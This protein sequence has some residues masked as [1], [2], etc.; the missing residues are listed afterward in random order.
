MDYQFVNEEHYYVEML[1]P[2][3]DPDYV[4]VEYNYNA[5]NHPQI[6]HCPND[7]PEPIMIVG[8]PVCAGFEFRYHGSS[9]QF[10]YQFGGRKLDH[11]L[12]CNC[13]DREVWQW[14][15]HIRGHQSLSL[16]PLYVDSFMAV[17]PYH[18][19]NKNWLFADFHAENDPRSD[20]EIYQYNRWFR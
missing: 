7:G 14:D 4:S 6:F 8:I 1:A 9:Y 2:Y 11:P 18:I 20:S 10:T 15:Y 5:D 3:A 12:S 16:A 13:P 19:E 17:S